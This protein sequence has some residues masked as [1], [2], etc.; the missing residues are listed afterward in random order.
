[1]ED[2]EREINFVTLAHFAKSIEAEMARELLANNG[3]DAVLQGAFFGGLEPLLTPGGF[4]E[5]QLLVPE[6]EFERARQLYEAFFE[7]DRQ[8]LNEDEEIEDV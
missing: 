8:A 3:V 2:R 4:S 7:S 6:D 5:I 1:M